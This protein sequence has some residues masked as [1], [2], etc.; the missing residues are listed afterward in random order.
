M[1]EVGSKYIAQHTEGTKEAAKSCESTTFPSTQRHWNFW[2][3]SW[4]LA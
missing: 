3:C 4:Q 1:Y 2:P